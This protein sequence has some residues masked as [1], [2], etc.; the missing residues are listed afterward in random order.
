MRSADKAKRCEV[1]AQH[2]CDKAGQGIEQS[3]S[4]FAGNSNG[5]ALRSREKPGA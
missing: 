2:R 5:I 1:R 4:S 3:R